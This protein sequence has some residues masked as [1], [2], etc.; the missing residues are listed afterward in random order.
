MEKQALHEVVITTA[1][2]VLP[3]ALVLFVSALAAHQ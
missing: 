1:V 3:I 2:S